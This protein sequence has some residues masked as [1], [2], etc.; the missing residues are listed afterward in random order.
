MTRG[1]TSD[2]AKLV[3]QTAIG[4]TLRSHFG[5]TEE[6]PSLFHSLLERMDREDALRLATRFRATPTIAPSCATPMA[7]DS[8]PE[9]GA[10]THPG[11]S[12]LTGSRDKA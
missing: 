9:K 3:A 4:Q 11:T 7:S 8:A 10:T 12:A 6:L 1:M 5:L 2:F